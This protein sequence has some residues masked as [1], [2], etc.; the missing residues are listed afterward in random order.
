VVIPSGLTDY[1]LVQVGLRLYVSWTESTYAQDDIVLAEVDLERMEVQEIFREGFS[2]E[3]V[4]APELTVH[5][6]LIELAWLLRKGRGRKTF[7]NVEFLSVD[8]LSGELGQRQSLLY[9]SQRRGFQLHSTSHGLFLLGSSTPGSRKPMGLR[10][11]EKNSGAWRSLEGPVSESAYDRQPSFR[12]GTKYL[13]LAWVRDGKVHMARSADGETWSE[14]QVLSAD[15]AREPMLFSGDVEEL[16]VAWLENEGVKS[17]IVRLATSPDQGDTWWHATHQIRFDGARSRLDGGFSYGTKHFLVCHYRNQEDPCEKLE[18]CIMSSDW[19]RERL[20]LFSEQVCETSL[21]P[22]FFRDDNGLYVTWRVRRGKETSLVMNHS[23]FPWVKWLNPAVEILESEEK[24][25]Y[26]GP[27][28][29][30][31]GEQMF[32]VYFVHRTSGGRFQ[33]VLQRGNLILRK[34]KAVVGDAGEANT[35]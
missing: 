4:L 21:S 11:F 1:A 5:E 29:V 24:A 14:P 35:G 33:K 25:V 20:D 30:F 28:L 31:L 10:L 6:G 3:K 8:P 23:E 32:V 26:V 13:H 12:C 16:A 17:S 18:F 9:G 34:L 2:A 27:K 7:H 19:K 22:A 15:G